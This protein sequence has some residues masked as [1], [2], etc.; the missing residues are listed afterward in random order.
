[1]TAAA[2][3]YAKVRFPLS[4]SRAAAAETLWAEPVGK[5]MYRLANIPFEVYGYAEGDIVK[6]AMRDGW[7]EPVALAKDSGNGTLRLLFGVGRASE[8][9]AVLEQLAAF[10]CGYERAS[11]CLVAV[12]VPPSLKVPFAHLCDYL[13]GLDDDLLPGWEVAK[14]MNRGGSQCRERTTH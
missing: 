9:K 1:M 7:A 5:N 14:P 2:P 8:G 6:C 4:R 12:T 10:G 13:N 3:S 11:D